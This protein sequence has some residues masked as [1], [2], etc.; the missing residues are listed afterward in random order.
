MKFALILAGLDITLIA[1]IVAL[2]LLGIAVITFVLI[3]TSKMSKKKKDTVQPEPEVSADEEKPVEPVPFAEAVD[4]IQEPVIVEEKAEEEVEEPAPAEEAVAEEVEEP[5]PAEEAVA[6]EAEEPAPVEEAVAEEAEEP[7]P[8]EEAV[9]EEA[10]EPLPVEE[11]VAEEVAEPAP[12]EEAVAEEAEEPAPAE[13]TVAE[14]VAEP[15]PVEEAVAEAVEEPAPVPAEKKPAQKIN[16]RVSYNRSFTAKIIQSDGVLKDYYSDIKNELLAYKKVKQRVSWRHETFRSGRK[17]L[18]KFTLRGKTLNVYFA[19]DPADYAD[20]KYK[21]KDV[22]SVACNANVPS[23]YKIK[24]ERRRRYA[25]QL[26]AELMQANGLEYAGREETD[27]AGQYP[28]E[29]TEAL[30]EKNL[31]KLVPWKEFASGSEVGVISVSEDEITEEIAAA[32]VAED[33]PAEIA[34]PEHCAEPED[35]DYVE[36]AVEQFF[37]E[38]EPAVAGDA[39]APE[40]SINVAEADEIIDDRYVEAFVRRSS[41]Y[42]DKTKKEVINIDTL[43]RYFG[44]GETVTLEEIKKRV[45]DMNK[46][47]TYIKVL[48]RGKLDKALTVEADDFS[49]QA[50]KMIVLTGGSAVK[51]K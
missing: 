4:V 5:A 36:E 10:E 17:L 32:I 12:V 40:M 42:S 31:I 18:A 37:D 19:L 29:E 27:Y 38:E 50:V 30:I 22:S 3:Y 41:K 48:A 47:V 24:N 44:A 51:H 14:E 43:G 16:I 34:E 1:G 25:K 7:A 35:E 33:A 21:I 6:E 9:S 49:P 20:T 13:E 2:V 28:Y 23:L 39:P 45:P 15:A 8:A 11:A 46:R 26:I